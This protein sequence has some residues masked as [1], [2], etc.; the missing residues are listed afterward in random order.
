VGQSQAGTIFDARNAST[1]GL[2]VQADNVTL[3]NFTL[4]GSTGSGGYG[5][6]V[7]PLDLTNPN[8]RINN[9]AINNVTINGSNKSALDI[10]GAHIATIDHVTAENAAAGVGIALIDSANVTI[11]NSTTLNNAWG[12]LRIEEKNASFN[13]QTNAVTVDATN[14]FNESVPVYLED[15]SASQNFGAVSIAG[16]NFLIGAPTCPPTSSPISRKR[17]RARS[18]MPPA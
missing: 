11:T 2:R 10:N 18:I 12:G 5:I 4:L 8:S 1:Y 14:T 17:S 16:F 9:F 7:E 13:Q 3:S 6:K 15:D